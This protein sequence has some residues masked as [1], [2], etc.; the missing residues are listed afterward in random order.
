MITGAFADYGTATTINQNGTVNPNGNY[1]K[2]A[3]K[4]GG[5]EVNSTALNKKA[6]STPP[7]FNSTTN[8]SYY[9]HGLWPHFALQRQWRVQRD[10]GHVDDHRELF[11]DSS[12][13]RER[14]AQG[15]MQ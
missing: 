4:Q 11:S 10:F 2:I 14:Q 8:C 1:V 5:F 6:N 12:A 9:L 13:L 7:T 15:P 3:L